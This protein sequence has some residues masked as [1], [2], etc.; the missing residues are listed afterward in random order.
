MAHLLQYTYL[1]SVLI[2]LAAVV[3]VS[4]ELYYASIWFSATCFTSYQSDYYSTSVSYTCWPFFLVA[5]CVALPAAA[6]G[7]ACSIAF[8]VRLRPDAPVSQAVLW[9]HIVI[10]ALLLAALL[11]GWIEPQLGYED[12]L[13]SADGFGG[14]VASGYL[15]ITG[16]PPVTGI[17]VWIVDMYNIVMP[18]ANDNFVRYSNTGQVFDAMRAGMAAVVLV[19]MAL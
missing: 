8:I 19:T 16:S 18:Y 11:I 12:E 3:S 9:T 6:L 15:S 13:P 1:L 5:W 7:L 17:F 4:V 2:Y 14:S 10:A